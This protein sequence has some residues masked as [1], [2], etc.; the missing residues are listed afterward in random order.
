VLWC[1]VVVWWWCGVVVWCGGG[2]VVVVWCRGGVVVSWCRGV[3]VSW[4]RGVVVLWWCGCT[5]AATLE[6]KTVPLVKV[7]VYLTLTRSPFAGVLPAP[8]F[9]IVF[10]YPKKKNTLIFIS[11]A[12]WTIMHLV[13]LPFTLE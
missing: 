5:F 3:V 1:G 8:F 6:S 13:S 11:L 4:C 12:L 10:V 9:I 7:P 2:G